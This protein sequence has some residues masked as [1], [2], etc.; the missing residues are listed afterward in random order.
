MGLLSFRQPFMVVFA[1][2]GIAYST[3]HGVIPDPESVVPIVITQML[4]NYLRGLVIACFLGAGMSTFVATINMGSA[5]WTRDIYQ[6]AIN[7]KAKPATLVLQGRLATVG[8][9]VVAVLVSMTVKSINDI[10]GWLT[11][12]L[13][14]ALFLPAAVSFYWS[15]MTA[16]SFI[17]TTLAG[18][19]GAIV[20]RILFPGSPEYINFTYMLVLSATALFITAKLSKI[21][22]K[23]ILKNFYQKVRPFGFWKS[24]Q[25][26]LPVE[27]IKKV[28]AENKRDFR[29]IW[30]ALIFQI[31]FYL[32]CTLFVMKAWNSLWKVA[33]VAA[34]FGVILYLHW[35]RHL[36]SNVRIAE[37]S[38]D[39]EPAKGIH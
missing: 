25:A 14:S 23:A 37:E 29:S 8:I 35:F 26:D 2:M 34:I 39:D 5:F 19:I 24:E 38:T 4:P 27:I 1:I 3:Q 12:S 13:A 17:S 32:M 15:K 7:P 9:V 10:W 18:L 16:F 36:D 20:Q 31:S 11:M 28:H 6:T 30:I 21:P 33:I 22:D